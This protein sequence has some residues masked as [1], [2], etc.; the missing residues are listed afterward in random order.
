MV[1][2]DSLFWTAIVRPDDPYR[3]SALEA[4]AGLE[5]AVIVTTE[6]V[7]SEFLAAVAK[8]DKHI[9]QAAVKAVDALRVSDQVRVG[10]QNESHHPPRMNS[11]PFLPL[12][13]FRLRQVR[14]RLPARAQHRTVKDPEACRLCY[15]LL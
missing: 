6:E 13:W 3:E 5:G 9:R 10:Q 8:Y 12:F 11:T 1:F 14:E 4:A 15:K 7:L 2:A